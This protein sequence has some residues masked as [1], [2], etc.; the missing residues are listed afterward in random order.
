MKNYK[1]DLNKADTRDFFDEHGFALF[2]NIFSPDEVKKMR[3]TLNKL[4]SAKA[5]FPGDWDNKDWIKALRA[6]LFNRYPELR[7]V[8][9]KTEIHQAL[10][11]VLGHDIG[12][13]PE[14]VAHY[15]GY[16]NWHKDTTSQEN[17]GV[18]IQYEPDWLMVECAIYLQDNSELYGGGLDVVP[19]SHRNQEDQFINSKGLG[20]ISSAI[21]RVKV[22]VVQ[23]IKTKNGYHIPSKAGDFV[24]FNKKLDHRASP[25]AAADMPKEKEK[26]AIFFIGGV[27]NQHLLEYTNYITTRPSYLYMH[28]YVVDPEFVRECNEQDITLILPSEKTRSLSSVNKTL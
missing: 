27:N 9:Y 25:C 8:F 26:L 24:F 23:T 11:K 18:K 14:S 3:E 4:F 1:F 20:Y 7:W 28:D 19:G 2:R 16:G 12:F 13:V 6:D 17:D 5:T 15:K 10:Q 21:N 22:P